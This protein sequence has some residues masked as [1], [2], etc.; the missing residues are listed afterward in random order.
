MRTVTPTLVGVDGVVGALDAQHVH[1]AV[2]ACKDMRLIIGEKLSSHLRLYFFL[3][4]RAPLRGRT[5]FSHIS[6]PC[7]LPFPPFLCWS[8]SICLCGDDL[9]FPFWDEDDLDAH[10]FFLVRLVTRGARGR[11]IE[12]FYAVPAPPLILLRFNLSLLST[13]CPPT[14]LGFIF[15]SCGYVAF[16]SPSGRSVSNT[17]SVH[18]L[19]RSFMLA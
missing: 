7:L 2:A 4:F 12:R 3:T 6:S 8:S 1:F 9:Q 5:L 10:S 15:R 19:L 18:R 17:A 16:W 13:S 11:V 14:F